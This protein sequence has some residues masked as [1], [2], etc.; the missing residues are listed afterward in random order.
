MADR[1]LLE[2]LYYSICKDEKNDITNQK[3]KVDFLCSK[4]G[5]IEW[6]INSGEGKKILAFQIFDSLKKRNI[7][8]KQEVILSSLRDDEKTNSVVVDIW[9]ENL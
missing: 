1:E 8:L 5:E 7:N 2:K 4:V 6:G 9:V 3:T